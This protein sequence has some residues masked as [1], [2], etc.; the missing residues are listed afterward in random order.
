MP[1]YLFIDQGGVLDGI[2]TDQVMEDDLLLTTIDQGLFQVLK[3]G[4]PLVKQLND[5]VTNYNYQIIFHSKNQ[6]AEQLS[7]LTNLSNACDLKGIIFP[8]VTAMA[9]RDPRYTATAAVTPIVINN[10]P[11]GILLAC[12]EQELDGKACVRLALSKL[13]NISEAER[14]NHIVLDDGPSVIATAIKEGWQAYEIGKIDLATVINAIYQQELIGYLVCPITLQLMQ[15][16]V[17]AADRFVYEEHAIKAWF[18]HCDFSPVTNF[19]LR[20]GAL[21]EYIDLKNYIAV[22]ADRPYFKQQVEADHKIWL[23]FKKQRCFEPFCALTPIQINL[24]ASISGLMWDSLPDIAKINLLQTKKINSYLLLTENFRGYLSDLTQRHALSPSGVAISTEQFW[25]FH[26]ELQASWVSNFISSLPCKVLHLQTKP[27]TM[28]AIKPWHFSAPQLQ[29]SAGEYFKLL[30]G[31]REDYQKILSCYEHHKV[32]GY[33]LAKVE[34]IYSP[35]MNQMFFYNLMLLQGRYQNPAFNPTWQQEPN[36]VSTQTL[37]RQTINLKLQEIAAPHVDSDFPA[38]KFLPL[39]HGTKPQILE[40][41]FKTGYANLGTTDDGCFGKGI[42]SAYEA[43]YAWRVYSQGVLIM[44]WVSMF[45]AFPT[46]AGDMPKLRGRSNY[47]NYDAHFVP[48][49]SKNPCDPRETEYF[50]CQPNQSAQYHEVVVFQQSQCLP[51]YLVTLQPSLP[52]PLL[53]SAKQIVTKN[54][55]FAL[56]AELSPE[57]Q[58]LLTSISYNHQ[59]WDSMLDEEK[60]RLLQS[61]NLN[62]YNFLGTSFRQYLSETTQEQRHTVFYKNRHLSTEEFWN[63]YPELQEKL[64]SK[65]SST[66]S[67]PRPSL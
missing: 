12:Y 24:I 29:L 7:L 16:P 14:A 15:H 21:I 19:A 44:N 40:S 61:N 26:Q 34:I 3:Q 51:R 9:V 49:A 13:L 31:V 25:N 5:L 35:A 46:I 8:K 39:W 10:R 54:Q 41:I 59:A 66:S 38:I 33:D 17:I 2:I 56:Y 32:P 52:K 48:V 64:L 11:H 43:E 55:C 23:K 67:Y 45:S 60:Q 58:A 50:P 27:I 63:N 1:K 18:N 62:S 28:G 37:W 47:M 4:V 30:P 36:D 20:D 53:F 65:K 57:A 42:Y 22:H 6:E